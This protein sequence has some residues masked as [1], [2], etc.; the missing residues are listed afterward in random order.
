MEGRQTAADRQGLKSEE[1]AAAK[2]G[3]NPR[4]S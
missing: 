3:R 2:G 4:R 1:Q